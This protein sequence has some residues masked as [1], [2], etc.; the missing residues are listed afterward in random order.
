MS[1]LRRA[2]SAVAAA[3]VLLLAG[4]QGQV[5][6]DLGTDAPADR[7]IQQ[8]TASIAG[9]EFRKDDGSLETL[10]FNNSELVDLLDYLDGSPIRLF[11]DEELPEGDYSGVRL[12]F[13]T[14]AAD[15]TQV[16]DVNNNAT[17]LVVTA[18][19]YADVDISVDEDSSSSDSITLTLDLRQSLSLD[20][21]GDE[22]TLQPFLRSVSTDDAGQ[23]T[24]TVNV[25]C[26]TGSTLAQGGAVYLFQGEDVVPDDRDGTGV[27]PY[28]TTEVST[29]G[30]YTLRFVPSGDYTIAVTCSGDEEDPA[31][32]DDLTFRGTDNV[33]L[34]RN[35]SLRFDFTS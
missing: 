27:E 25:T 8:V 13:D 26:P 5:S 17:P 30:G 12:V 29:A 15:D 3:S 4:C 19:N 9:L 11:T 14:D 20:S 16:V 1:L 18:G 10:S 34:D 21:D 33:Q 22:Y 24:G 2:A 28:A 6:V 31:S 32:N 35:E 7:D 23:I